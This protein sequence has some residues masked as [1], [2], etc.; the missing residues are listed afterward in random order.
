MA[1]SGLRVDLLGPLEVTLDGREIGVPGAKARTALAALALTPG[2]PVSMTRLV[3]YLWAEQLPVN[4]RASL[5]TVITRLRQALEADVI[6]AAAESYTLRVEPDAIDLYRFR[7]LLGS[8]QGSVDNSSSHGS[9]YGGSGGGG[10]AYGGSGNSGELVRVEQA[11]ALWRG[12]PL[13]DIRS[14]LLQSDHANRIRD[15]WLAARE[16]R[17]DLLLDAGGHHEVID[18][19]RELVGSD[20]LR[21]SLWT[22]LVVALYRSGR[23]ADAL[24]AYHE[25]RTRLRD[26]LG[27]D[28]EPGLQQVH[29]AVLTQASSLDPPVRADPATRPEQLPADTHRTAGRQEYLD[30]LDALLAEYGGTD[31]TTLIAALDGAAGVGKT[32][33]AVHW[34]HRVKGEFPAGQLYVNLRGYGIGR[35]VEPETALELMLRSLGIEPERIPPGADARSALLRTTL[36]GRRALVLLDNA[37]DTEQVRPLLPGSGSVVVVTSRSQLRGL[38]A[39]NG[40]HRLTVE[41]LADDEAAGLLRHVIGSSRADA[42]PVAVSELIRL[43]ARLPLAILLAGDRANRQPGT[44]LADLA[45]ELRTERGRLDGL[46][47]GDDAATDLRTVFSWSYRALPPAA[48]RAF[49]LLGIAPGPDIMIRAAA[50]LLGETEPATRQL[51]DALVNANQLQLKRSG[52]YELHDLI[53][54]YASELASQTDTE[55]DRR[56]A[57]VRL[58]RWYQR[59]A[60][61]ARAQVHPSEFDTSAL[62]LDRDAVPPRLESGRDALAWYNAE[63]A[64]FPAAIRLALD[65]GEYRLCWSLAF[66]NWIALWLRKAW[67]EMIDEHQ[68]GR[69]AARRDGDQV[70]EGNML[71]GIGAAYRGSGDPGRAVEAQTAALA[72]LRVAGDEANRATALSNLGAANRDLGR[73]VAALANFD[74]AYAIDEARG[75]TGNMAISLHQTALTL[76]AAGRYE[77]AIVKAE[78]AI[79]LF[80]STGNPLHGQGRALQAAAAAHARLGHVDEAIANSR[81]AAKIFAEVGDGWQLSSTLH[82]LGALLRDNGEPAAARDA[83][84]EA[85]ELLTRLDPPAA[86]GLRSE[87][88]ALP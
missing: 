6:S 30:R 71:G 36:S 67:T 83:W 24:D 21:E 34:A 49:R 45:E 10:S 37:R 78:A 74:E 14:D 40:A 41:P 84:Q 47:L 61:E 64:N 73:Y 9:A 88:S 43:C 62:D 70:A 44:P 13:E 60:F 55:A 79:R 39:V 68:L 42:E 15:E 25:I 8:H 53:R 48:A 35:P 56:A 29:Q 31:R 46:D 19:L 3:S 22:R 27:L 54:T 63:H 2:R 16:R 76:T 86:A 4:P 66:A 20:P 38:V 23:Q 75:E 77:E 65:L 58:L 57:L 59:S 28:P 12:R 33:L 11:L 18:E 1:S 81:E 85:I 51:L 82:T 87:L 7:S 32:T 80:R 26:E 50:A 72:I 52:R 5:Y 17:I 69:E